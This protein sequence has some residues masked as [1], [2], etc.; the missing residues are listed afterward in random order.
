[1][2]SRIIFWLSLHASFFMLKSL[3]S[4]HMVFFVQFAI[5][6]HKALITLA[7]V[8][9]VIFSFLNN[10]LVQIKSRLKE[11]NHGNTY[12]YNYVYHIDQVTSEARG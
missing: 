6:L 11:K 10:A 9:R 3:L 5:N 4:N 1:M 12:G 8:T 2:P 7:K